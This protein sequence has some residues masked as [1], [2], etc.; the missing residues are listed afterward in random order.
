MVCENYIED[1]DNKL[2][3]GFGVKGISFNK[4]YGMVKMA[5][6]PD[7]SGLQLVYMRNPW[8]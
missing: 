4:A 7:M 1:D 8:G 5:Y 6:L 2:V 3:E